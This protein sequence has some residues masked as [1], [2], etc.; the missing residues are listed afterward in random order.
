MKSIAVKFSKRTNRPTSATE[1]GSHINTHSGTAVA[2]VKVEEVETAE[3]DYT[4]IRKSVPENKPELPVAEDVACGGGYILAQV[5]PAKRIMVGAVGPCRGIVL[6]LI[7]E[8]EVGW[9]YFA[10]SNHSVS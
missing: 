10:E 8:G 5:L 6:P 3:S 9:F 1:L 4:V 7:E 2:R